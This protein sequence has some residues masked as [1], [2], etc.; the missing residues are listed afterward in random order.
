MDADACVASS[1]QL[2]PGLDLHAS[3]LIGHF[4]ASDVDCWV[5]AAA[6]AAAAGLVVA[7]DY[8]RGQQLV[9]DRDFDQ[10]T[11]RGSTA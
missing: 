1:L 2:R 7:Q 4:F 10:V 9:A 5:A 8:K 11:R 6:A 3:S